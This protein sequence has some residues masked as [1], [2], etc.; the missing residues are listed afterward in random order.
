[1]LYLFTHS[2]AIADEAER[3]FHV[4]LTP[5]RPALA[6]MAPDDY[7]SAFLT[8]DRTGS[9]LDSMQSLIADI[10]AILKMEVHLLVLRNS[11]I[12]MGF[13][14]RPPRLTGNCNVVSIDQFQANRG[15]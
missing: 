12:E 5:A 1:M 13:E 15:R 11:E 4:R 14:G 9:W 3:N 7:W 8:H 10:T 2:T 6:V